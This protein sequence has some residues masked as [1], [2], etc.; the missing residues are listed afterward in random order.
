REGIVALIGS[1]CLSDE[2]AVAGFELDEYIR[3]WPARLRAHLSYDGVSFGSLPG[4]RSYEKQAENKHRREQGDIAA[5]DHCP[6]FY[7]RRSR[8]RRAAARKAGVE[9][10]CAPPLPRLSYRGPP[11]R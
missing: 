9:Q 8:T 1:D 6:V 3:Y 4:A 10:Y 7:G 2:N 11:R 5:T